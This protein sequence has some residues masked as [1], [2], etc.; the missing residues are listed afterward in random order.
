MI[1]AIFIQLICFLLFPPIPIVQQVRR[2]SRKTLWLLLFYQAVAKKNNL[3]RSKGALN[4]RFPSIFFFFF[5]ISCLQ[6][7]AHALL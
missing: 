6:S 1:L 7:L 4:L 3:P 2:S 5:K